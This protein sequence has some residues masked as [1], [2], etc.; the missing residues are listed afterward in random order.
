MNHQEFLREFERANDA[1]KKAISHIDG[2]LLVIAG[3]GSGKTRVATMRIAHLVHSGVHPQ[4]IL[5]VTFTNKAAK[6]MKERV[7]KLVGSYVHVSTFHSLG[8]TILRRHI[9]LLSY[10]Q[11]FAIYAEEESKKIIKDCLQNRGLSHKE[12]D[13]ASF[14]K[15][16]S[17]IK[18]NFT[19]FEHH[20]R[21][22]QSVFEQYQ[23]MLQKSG[24]VDFDDLIFLPLRLF[25][26]HPQVIE[27]VNS[28]FTYLLVDEYQDTSTCQSLF[29]HALAG[30]KQ[31]IFA[32][33]DPD[34][35]IYSWRGAKVENI[36]QFKT[37]YPDAQIVRLEQNYRSTN[38]ILSASNALIKHNEGRFE[39][40]LWSQKGEGEAI[41]RHLAQSERQ[42]A[43]FVLSLANQ[44]I[45]SGYR[46]SD[47]AILYRTNAQSRPIED[48]CI[49]HKIPYMIFGGIPFY[50]RREVKDI[51]SFLQIALLPQDIIS[52]ERALKIL[53]HGIGET[54]RA[55]IRQKALETGIP[56]FETAKQFLQENSS[57][58]KKQRAGLE[59]FCS[60][61]TTLKEK[62]EQESA[63]EIIS[64]AIRDSGYLSLLE[65]EEETVTER[66]ENLEQLL[67]RAQEW[68]E[69]HME[70]SPTLFLEELL[71]EGNK[72]KGNTEEEKIILA[73]IH[74]AKGLEFP[75]VFIIG[76]EEDLFPHINAKLSDE[77]LEEERRL[78]Y[79]GMTRAKEKLA[80][81]ASMNRFV[82]GGVRSMRTSRFLKEIPSNFIKPYTKT[83]TPT[84]AIEQPSVVSESDFEIGQHVF[85]PQFGIGRIE[86]RSESSMGTCYEVFFSSDNKMK[87]IIAKYAS[88][89]ALPK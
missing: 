57:L 66:K 63:F 33:G 40:K 77:G 14:S 7:S 68:D 17:D 44:Y 53:G 78:L 87:K 65:K 42:E 58:S 46:P 54:T 24:A 76:L 27:E 79:V 52:F 67:G 19:S 43:E 81:S 48:R 45:Q 37:Q 38:T 12:A 26:E 61:I 2:P 30:R 75:I 29:A 89:R 72:D 59:A 4:S 11:N 80:L 73:T 8:A 55:K 51:L 28:S 13:I 84:Q 74:N 3:A 49:E 32:V 88:M 50:S 20:S 71:L 39:K 23:E 10:P 64:F 60:F 62:T 31:N 16:F 41:I 34:Q 35:S 21:L 83:F 25:K 69:L 9:H 36:L 18:N 56:I 1:Q 85:H 6:E 47:I 22:T 82:F 15:A 86:S 5:A 70:A